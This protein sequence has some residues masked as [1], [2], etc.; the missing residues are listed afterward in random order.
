MD[1]A[2]PKGPE[3]Q[4]SWWAKTVGFDRLATTVVFT[5]EKAVN[6]Y[7]NMISMFVGKTRRKGLAKH[8]AIVSVGDFASR[9]QSYC[10]TSTR[11][12][13]RIRLRTRNQPA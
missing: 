5:S 2:I 11:T 9:T 3:L 13:R 4:Q 1:T 8:G 7:A 6:L 10:H 12:I